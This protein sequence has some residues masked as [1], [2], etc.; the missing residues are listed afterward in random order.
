[1]MSKF[2]LG[3]PE[4]VQGKV[5]D[6]SSLSLSQF[7]LRGGSSWNYRQHVLISRECVGN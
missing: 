5:R 6:H 7:L 2:G 1:M 4:G 3:T